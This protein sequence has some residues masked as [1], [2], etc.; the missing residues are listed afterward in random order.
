MNATTRRKNSWLLPA[1]L[2][3]NMLLLALLVTAAFLFRERLLQQYLSWRGKARI[4]FFG[5]SIM[6]Q[7]KWN[8]LLNRCDIRNSGIPGLGVVHLKEEVK[9]KVIAYEPS[10]CVVMAGINDL[11]I[12]ERTA[13]QACADYESILMQ[14][15]DASVKTV[16]QLTLYERQSPATR[17]KVDSLNRWLVSFCIKHEITY[18]DPNQWLSDHEGLQRG[19]AGDRTHLTPEAYQTWA[20]ALQPVVDRLAN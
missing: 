12:L 7:G 2:T 3:L 9:S 6:A 14:L 1:S 8:S 4:V 11:T 15:K 16:V 17:V 19:Y 13:A 20:E 10:A 18:S 5:D